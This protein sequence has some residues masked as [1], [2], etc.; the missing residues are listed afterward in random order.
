M[1]EWSSSAAPDDVPSFGAFLDPAGG[2]ASPTGSPNR[3]ARE[4]GEARACRSEDD[5][6]AVAIIFCEIDAARRMDGGPR[7]DSA[8]QL[9]AEVAARL[10]GGLRPGDTVSQI[11]GDA[12]VVVL[13]GVADDHEVQSIRHRLEQRLAPPLTAGD[14]SVWIRLSPGLAFRGDPLLDGTA[15]AVSG[16]PAG[17]AD[18]AMCLRKDPASG[19]ASDGSLGRSQLLARDLPRAAAR[20]EITVLYQSQVDLATGRI[21]AVE[22]LARWTHPVLGTVYPDEFIP[23]AE[24][25]GE[26]TVIGQA[27]RRRA[28]SDLA[29]LRRHHPGLEL[30]VNVSVDE[31]GSRFV[32]NLS[33]VLDSVGLPPAALTVELTE[34]KLPE[35]RL[36]AVRHLADVRAL[37]V[38][39][40]LDDFGTG[41]TSLA[42]LRD[43]PV[44][45]IKV[46]RSFVQPPDAGPPDLLPGIVGLAHGLGLRA[47]AEGVSSD[48]DLRRV[49]NAGFDRGQ[50]FGLGT[51]VGVDALARRLRHAAA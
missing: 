7:S 50:G 38:G 39:I 21:V 44:T 42:Q 11:A 26:I 18:L 46:D 33:E 3:D 45:E 31:L 35:D 41:F 37:G 22:A 24:L 17:P 36:V 27:V 15:S 8:G 14:D 19:S 30:A 1:C 12:F 51:P 16:G 20:G 13:D 34:S 32:R 4:E 6:G 49:R 48:A 47:V 23:I 40:A 43:V 25:K 2:V 29:R 28:C 9:L 10:R 5:R